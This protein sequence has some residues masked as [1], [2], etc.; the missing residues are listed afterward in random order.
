LKGDV[1][2][3]SRVVVEERLD[4]SGT[5]ALEPAPKGSI[6]KRL[7]YE[8]ELVARTKSNAVREAQASKTSAGDS[9]LGVIRDKS[10]GG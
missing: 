1:V 8:Y 5:L 10:S 4:L 3:S 9:G 7:V 6:A 2:R